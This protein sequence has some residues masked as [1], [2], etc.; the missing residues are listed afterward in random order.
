MHPSTQKKLAWASYVLVLIGG[1]NW[2]LIGLGGFVGDYWN[3]INLVLGGMPQLE[4]LVYIM[5]GAAAIYLAL[6]HRPIH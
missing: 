1:M 2:G 5:I 6:K 4:W 3:I